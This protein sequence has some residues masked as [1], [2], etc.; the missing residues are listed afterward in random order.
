MKKVWLKFRLVLSRNRLPASIVFGFGIFLFFLTNFP[1]QGR[2]YGALVVGAA[3]FIGVP[4]TA[5]LIGLAWVGGMYVVL[6][7]DDVGYL[8][9][10]E[11]QEN[12]LRKIYSD[13]AIE[14]QDSSTIKM[15][16]WGKALLKARGNE[17]LAK[18][19]YIEI[20]VKDATDSAK[21]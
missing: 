15:D 19:K 7:F 3:D 4:L 14:L 13:A 18:A 8:D 9:E 6:E 1:D 11:K 16:V 5:F 2:R 12:E 10:S 21:E 20:R 17:E